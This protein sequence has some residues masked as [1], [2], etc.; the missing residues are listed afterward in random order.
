MTSSFPARTFWLYL[1]IDI[2]PAAGARYR[3]LLITSSNYGTKTFRPVSYWPASLLKGQ[4][5]TRL[6]KEL[7]LEEI[8]RDF[9]PRQVSR[10]HSI[11]LWGSQI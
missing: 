6:Q 5:N 4:Q 11:Y 7:R 8:R 9:N 1:N 10:L 3:G 2:F